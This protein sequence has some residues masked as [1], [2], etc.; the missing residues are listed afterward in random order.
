MNSPRRSFL[1]ASATVF[2]AGL[3]GCISS[4]EALQQDNHG[5]DSEQLR[6]TAIEPLDNTPLSLDVEVF[7]GGFTDAH[8]PLTLRLTIENRLDEPVHFGERRNAQFFMDK[9]TEPA[10][11]YI[12][13]PASWA[14]SHDGEAYE[15]TGDCWIQLEYMSWTDD[16]QVEGLEPDESIQTDLLFLTA[17]DQRID[18]PT[19][20][21]PKGLPEKI[22]FETGLRATTGETFFTDDGSSWE[23]DWGIRLS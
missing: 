18:P 3:A 19:P 4:L 2:G 13:I 21:C 20:D 17:R 23:F 8:A 14:E 12:L 6:A 7:D 16:Y 10:G 1:A 15:F 9:S 11:T 22:E 5:N